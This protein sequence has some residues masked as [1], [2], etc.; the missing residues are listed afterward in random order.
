MRRPWVGNVG[1]G[2]AENVMVESDA[3]HAGAIK[4]AANRRDYDFR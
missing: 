3:E 4:Y 1:A 2:Y